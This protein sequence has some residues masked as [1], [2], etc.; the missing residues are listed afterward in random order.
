M[1]EEAETYSRSASLPLLSLT[2]K[3]R[4]MKRII[5][6]LVALALVAYLLP[7]Q[8][9]NSFAMEAG[10]TVE[11]PTADDYR[12]QTGVML[13][14]QA[15]QAY[16]TEL[17]YVLTPQPA[18]RELTL[19]L[20]TDSPIRP[21]VYLTDTDGNRL[22]FEVTAQT[23]HTYQQLRLDVKKLQEGMY[24]LVVEVPGVGQSE[25]MPIIKL[26]ALPVLMQ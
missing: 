16:Q 17:N 8:T 11:E 24:F 13:L 12:T 5:S 23:P 22:P 21:T 14:S 7:A 3:D 26:D 18:I 15:N 10:T 9:P 6:L 19:V 20:S 4:L 25:G 2:L 1:R